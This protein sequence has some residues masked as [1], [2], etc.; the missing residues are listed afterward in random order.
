MP[1][2]NLQIDVGGKPFEARLA[3][4]ARQTQDLILTN[5]APGPQKRCTVR[6]K[7]IP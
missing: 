1:L 2:G 3:P 6:W 5:K 4:A 7:L